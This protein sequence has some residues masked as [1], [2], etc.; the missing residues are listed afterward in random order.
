MAHKSIMKNPST[1]VTVLVSATSALVGG[2][3]VHQLWRSGKLG[4]PDPEVV[5]TYFVGEV[6]PGVIPNPRRRRARRAR[7]GPVARVL[8]PF[9]M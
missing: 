8:L 6:M 7:R 9:L 4:K 5:Q 3:V 2:A 1:L